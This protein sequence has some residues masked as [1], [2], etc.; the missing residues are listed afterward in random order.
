MPWKVFAHSD[1]PLSEFEL[2]QRRRKQKQI[3]LIGCVIPLVLV[4][5]YLSARPAL[6]AIRGWQARRHAGSALAAIDKR[7]W[8]QARDEAFAAY[9]LL[10]TEPQAI[11][12]VARL[13]SRARQPDGLR[14]W[15][16]LREHGPLTRTD[17]RDEASLALQAHE[18][19]VAA[20]ATKELLDARDGGP[21]PADWLLN[22]QLDVQRQDLDAATIYIRQ[23]FGSSAATAADRLQATLL[24]DAILRSKQASD[25][26]EVFSRLDALARGSDQVSLDALVALAQ[27]IQTSRP[28][29]HNADAMSAEDTIRALEAHPLA[30]TEHKLLAIDLRIHEH[31]E[32]K[33]KLIAAAVE[34]YRSADTLAL[35]GLALWL[36]SHGEY[37]RELVAIPRQRAMESR[38]L[39]LQH[40]DAMGALGQWDEIR[41]LI[42]SEQFPLDPV[43]EHM[44]LARAF[45]QQGQTGG[46]E[47]SWGRALKAAAGD[48]PKLMTLG[49]YA[50]KN[51]ALNIARAAYDAVVAVSPRFRLAQ[52]GRLHVAYALRDTKNI[53]AILAELLERW[54]NDTAVQNDE[55]YV[56][57]L[58]LPSVSP[59]QPSLNPLP[60]MPQYLH[61][62]TSTAADQAAVLAELQSIE[63]LAA[64]LVANEPASLPHRTLLAL[65]RLK[66]NQPAKAMEVYKGITVPNTALTSTALAVH[67]AVLEA[68]GH[69]DDARKEFSEIPN[70]K[71]LPEEARLAP[72]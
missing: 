32:E 6:H 1:L 23:V 33:E 19:D 11:R 69:S 68:N 43:V 27:R 51:G 59:D 20:Q 65:A 66:L 70:D 57:L 4:I 71:L 17:L 26:G 55:A 30:T 9:Q 34:Q 36:N 38:E 39:F 44:Y 25:L 12:A 61:S 7:Q 35:S 3:I 50:G 47:N 5:G 48:V 29:S 72:R 49:D 37:Q 21:A 28:G 16:D 22:A 2:D 31:P 45:A 40:V 58:L 41:Y 15:K 53:R 52:Q 60:S 67:A 54:P 14:F 46:A 42:Q 64:K 18:L 62:S 56:R 24:L 63:A 10:S 13:F 8:L